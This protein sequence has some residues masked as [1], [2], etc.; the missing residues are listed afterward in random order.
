VLRFA[1]RNG[2]P[3]PERKYRMDVLGTV[4][5]S[6]VVAVV[7]LLVTW[8]GKGRFDAVDRQIDRLDRRIDGLETRIDAVRSELTQVALAVGAKPR[9]TN[10]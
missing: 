10:A 1:G 3:P 2:G 5:T 8:F 6:V 7:G 4:I 9:A